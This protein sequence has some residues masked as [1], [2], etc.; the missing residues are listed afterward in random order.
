M[1]TPVGKR[2]ELEAKLR[3]QE[4]TGCQTTWDPGECPECG[5]RDESQPEPI[6]SKCGHAWK[7]EE[8]PACGASDFTTAELSELLYPSEGLFCKDCRHV[9]SPSSESKAA[10][11]PECNSENLADSFPEIPD[12]SENP[13][14]YLVVAAEACIP[15]A[16]NGAILHREM[17]SWLRAHG[18]RNRSEQLKWEQWFIAIGSMRARVLEEIMAPAPQKKTEDHEEGYGR[19]S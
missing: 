3:E 16:E 19:G 18:V 15:R 5:D 10:Q 6:C 12:F 1:A 2:R 13:L 7:P 9:W 14:L 8:C 11:C 4:C 17:L